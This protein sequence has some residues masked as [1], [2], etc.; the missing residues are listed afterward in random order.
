MVTM[1][2]LVLLESKVLQVLGLMV[3]QVL[4]VL[5]VLLVLLGSRVRQEA[6]ATDRL[7]LLVPLDPLEIQVLLVL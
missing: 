3:K 1:G 7:V 4:Q 6:L 2:R 5:W